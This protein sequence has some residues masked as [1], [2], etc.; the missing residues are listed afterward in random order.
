MHP[1]QIAPLIKHAL[2]DCPDVLIKGARQT[3]KSTLVQAIADKLKHRYLTLDYRLN[4]AAA[5]GVPAG[6]IAGLY[7]SDDSVVMGVIHRMPKH[8]LDI[9]ATVDQDRTPGRFLLTGSADVLLLPQLADSLAGRIEIVHLWPLSGGKRAKDAACNRAELL[10]DGPFAKRSPPQQKRSTF[11][12]ISCYKPAERSSH[13]PTACLP[14]R[15]V[16]C[17]H[18]LA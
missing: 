14:F 4:L 8:F 11:V 9:K 13:S 17:G 16:C 5:K 2:A 7:R 15:R 12:V 6:L 3:G 18:K 1:R 10:F